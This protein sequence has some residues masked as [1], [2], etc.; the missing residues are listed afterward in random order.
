MI[1][2]RTLQ[3][4]HRHSRH[5]ATRRTIGLPARRR[6]HHL[7]SVV[8]HNR[9]KTRFAVGGAAIAAAVAF[10]S[11]FS[12]S[13]CVANGEDIAAKGMNVKV[14]YTGTLTDG[15]VFDSSEGREPLAFTVGAGQMIPGF[16]AGVVG[17]QVGETKELSLPPADAYGEHDERG[18]QEVPVAN[19]PEG[20]EVGAQLE[21]QQGGRAVV[22]EINGDTAVVDLNHPLAGQ[23]LQF[24]ITLV[25]CEAAP[26]LRVETLSPGDG[27]T[28]PKSGDKL[29]MHYTGTL[30]SNGKKF[31]SSVDRGQP[32]Q[33]TIGVGQVIQ[34]WDQGVIQMSLGEKAKLHI[35]S[36]LGYGERGAGGDIPPNA[37]LVFEVEL[38]NIN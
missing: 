33:F 27:Q 30:A 8:G 7:S 2:R 36:A 6:L 29:T 4:L 35:P 3:S 5:V 11:S 21:T 38:L 31:D 13:F 23:T 22:K 18:V 12:R 24:K 17:M 16:D 9:L 20:I 32:F 15:S 37:D 14:E 1:L 28:Y 10:P 26:E 25:A 34:G 19:L